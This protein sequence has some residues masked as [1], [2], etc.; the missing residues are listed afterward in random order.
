MTRDRLDQ[1]I[2]L[3]ARYPVPGR[4]KTRLIPALGVAGAARLHRRMTE[5]VVCEA[6]K[7]RASHSASGFRMSFTGG[8]RRDFRAWLG[9]DVPLRRQ[10]SG[11]LGRRMRRAFEMEFANSANRV[12]AVGADVPGVTA[13]LMAQAMAMLDGHDVVIGPARDGGYWLLGMKRTIPELFDGIEWGGDQ[14]FDQTLEICELRNLA[15]GLLPT[16]SDVDRPEDLAEVRADPRFN[17]VFDCDPRI[18]VVVPT[19]NEE[20][21]IGATLAELVPA[22]GVVE[23]LVADGG[24]ADRTRELAEAAGA[25]VLSVAGGRAAQQNAAAAEAQ[26]RALLFLH[27]D[28]RPP[29]DFAD[30]IRAAL[31]D[32]A[33]V[34]GAFR[35]RTDGPGWGMRV[36]EWGVNLR[37][38]LL[39]MPYGDQGLF[40]ETRVFEEVGGFPVQPIMED[41][42]LV[43]RLRSRGR[44][45][46]LGSSVLT[47]AR[48]WARLGVVRTTV[49][50]WLMVLGYRVGMPVERLTRLYRGRGR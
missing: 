7:F 10:V 36:V 49:V 14:V 39:R 46:L 41:Y 17:D 19:L 31:D 6:R 45:V 18:S 30:S 22:P 12:A 35:F 25:R 24:S 2:L 23:V 50:N 1:S 5:A 13:G 20:A 38:R 33:A 32:P 16:L 28:T 9:C 40:M 26:G 43:R 37:S 34:A 8:G 27:A 3:F 44:V 4:A 11:D 48:R 21:T 47:S 29:A 42:E 15:V